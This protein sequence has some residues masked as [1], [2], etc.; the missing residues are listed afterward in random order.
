YDVAR[1]SYTDGDPNRPVPVIGHAQTR[2]SGFHQGAGETVLAELV[3]VD[4]PQYSIL[5]IDEV[6]SSLHPKLQ[7]RLIR[8]LAELARALELQIVLTTHSPIILDE[9]PVEARAQIM[10]SNESR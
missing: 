10:L 4:I 6:E 1:M 7:R 2:Y 5:L 9:L 8:D 3:Q